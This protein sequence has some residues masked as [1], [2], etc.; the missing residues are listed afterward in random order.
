MDIMLCSYYV[1]ISK[2]SIICYSVSITE[3][4]GSIYIVAA[5]AALAV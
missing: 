2:I 1:T 5:V 3:R 4:Y